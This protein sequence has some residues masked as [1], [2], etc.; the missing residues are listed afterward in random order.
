[1]AI[2]LHQTLGQVT[3]YRGD[4]IWDDSM[5]SQELNVR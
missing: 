3:T 4:D 2:E 1:M 5:M